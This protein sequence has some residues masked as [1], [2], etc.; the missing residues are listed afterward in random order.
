M[1]KSQYPKL[2]L[3]EE[4]E[5]VFAALCKKAIDFGYISENPHVY[6][7]G[8]QIVLIKCDKHNRDYFIS[9][10]INNCFE[11]ILLFDRNFISSLVRSI[12]TH[13]DYN[14]AKE[15]FDIELEKH[16]ARLAVL[17]ESRRLSYLKVTFLIK[18]TN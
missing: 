1:I 7:S 12:D 13:D 3:D 11:N 5:I 8:E 10:I 16:L 18:Y 2:V 6:A 15:Y 17:E 9:D 14:K 4:R